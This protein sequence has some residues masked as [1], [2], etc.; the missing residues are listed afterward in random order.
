MS[1][2]AIRAYDATPR[3]TAVTARV[4]RGEC[5]GALSFTTIGTTHVGAT[6]QAT[7]RR[8]VPRAAAVRH[9]FSVAS[10]ESVRDAIF[11][12]R[13]LLFS[14]TSSPLLAIFRN[15]L[16]DTSGGSGR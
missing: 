14:T 9:D 11:L 7:Y 5:D 13:H 4:R 1:L 2:I 15:A 16:T 3:G 12:M 10:N 6:V 8:C